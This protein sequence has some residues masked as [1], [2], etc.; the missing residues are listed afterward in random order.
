MTAEAEGKKSVA[1]EK[2][3]R[4]SVEEV[5]EKIREKQADTPQVIEVF[6]RIY[7]WAK[8]SCDNIRTGIDRDGSL[9]PT[10][11]T[12]DG[13]VGLF[14]LSG[15]GTLWTHFAFHARLSQFHET[16]SRVEVILKFNELVGTDF[17]AETI[18]RRPGI[19]LSEFSNKYS[20][21]GLIQY[22][23]WLIDVLRS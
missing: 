9:I 19:K 21:D 7:E 20:I 22:Y 16:E 5:L 23:E 13:G 14:S 2:H 18:E 11:K 3:V 8:D 15:N 17:P 12:D 6:M 1:R 4:R 10:I